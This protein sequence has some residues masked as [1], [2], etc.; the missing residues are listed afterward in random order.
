MNIILRDTLR[1]A[2][3]LLSDEYKANIDG[4]IKN[5]VYD[6]TYPRED[7]GETL[8]AIEIRYLASERAKEWLNRQSTDCS[9]IFK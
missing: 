6:S 1:D 4:I 5:I 7:I 8:N 2:L 9:C 3:N